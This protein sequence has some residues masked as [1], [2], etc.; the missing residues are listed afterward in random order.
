M[1]QL[2]RVMAA[3]Q[4]STS[5]PKPSRYIFLHAEPRNVHIFGRGNHQEEFEYHNHD[6]EIGRKSQRIYFN[7]RQMER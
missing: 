6:G 1:N 5:G 3:R 7:R 4:I 2:P